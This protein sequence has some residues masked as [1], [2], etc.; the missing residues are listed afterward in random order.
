MF[1]FQKKHLYY[2]NNRAY[3]NLFDYFY[4]NNKILE[5][6][7]IC[8]LLLDRDYQDAETHRRL[9]DI[10]NFKLQDYKNAIK[11]YEYFTSKVQNNA[12]VNHCLKELYEKV[13]A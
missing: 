4:E 11:E 3:F 9:G 13:N 5:A 12:A 7:E 10:Y 8:N 2:K 1:P 6:K